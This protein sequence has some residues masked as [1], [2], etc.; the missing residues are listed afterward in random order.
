MAV[1]RRR[2][3]RWELVLAVV[4]ALAAIVTAIVPDWIEAVFGVDP[5]GGDGSLEWIVVA[6]LA[7]IALALTVAGWRNARAPAPDPS[8]PSAH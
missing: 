1:P 2:R 5:D 4:A 7:V 6:V 3:A 8:A